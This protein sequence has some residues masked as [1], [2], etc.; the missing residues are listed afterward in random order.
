M[1]EWENGNREEEV[2]ELEHIEPQKINKSIPNHQVICFEAEYV[3]FHCVKPVNSL[4]IALIKINHLIFLSNAEQI[5]QW[6]KLCCSNPFLFQS[7]VSLNLEN[8]I[9]RNLQE[10]LHLSPLLQEHFALLLLSSTSNSLANFHNPSFQL[11]LTSIVVAMVTILSET[12]HNLLQ[13]YSRL[14]VLLF[15]SL[16]FQ[17]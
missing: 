11:L 16:L 1:R 5:H 13:R 3:S 6:T 10:Q 2:K 14:L 17:S 8:S 15:R 4:K 7:N 9:L 12:L